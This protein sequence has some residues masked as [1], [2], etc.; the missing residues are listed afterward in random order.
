[1]CYVLSFFGEAL[2]ISTVNKTKSITANN[3]EI[4]IL[5]IEKLFL[6]YLSFFVYIIEES[7]IIK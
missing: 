1:M 5:F 3:M 2:K 6:N 7:F 4:K